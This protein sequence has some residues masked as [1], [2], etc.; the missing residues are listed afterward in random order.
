MKINKVAVISIVLMIAIACLM[1]FANK[2]TQALGMGSEE[3][4]SQ[5]LDDI[6]S[7]QKTIL[8]EISAIKEELKIIKIRVTQSQ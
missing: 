3:G 8:A 4:V 5:K 1:I 2:V 7:S 6:L